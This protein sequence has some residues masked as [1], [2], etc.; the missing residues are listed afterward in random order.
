MTTNGDKF[1]E[2]HPL[3]WPNTKL[4]FKWCPCDLS[5]CSFWLSPW[6]FFWNLEVL[7]LHCYGQVG[8]WGFGGRLAA[9]LE[10]RSV[11]T[12]W[13]DGWMAKGS[14]E[15]LGEGSSEKNITMVLHYFDNMLDLLQLFLKGLDFI[16]LERK[17]WWEDKVSVG[18]RT[19]KNS[20]AISL[21]RQTLKRSFQSSFTNKHRPCRKSRARH[22]EALSA[23][24]EGSVDV[25]LILH[26]NTRMYVY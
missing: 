12:R 9:T 8:W 20:P 26:V 21:P 6:F 16:R 4:N 25:F 23:M 11:N 19:E 2:L 17:C 24:D 18:V 7:C 15:T 5:K 14:L 10:G 22:I 3:C 1:S 13:R